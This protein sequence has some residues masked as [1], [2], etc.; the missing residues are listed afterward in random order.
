MLRDVAIPN[1]L[2]VYGLKEDPEVAA[3]AD[4]IAFY[5]RQWVEDIGFCAEEV[6][7]SKIPP[8]LVSDAQLKNLQWK[9][10]IVVGT[11]NDVVKELGLTFEKPT[12]KMLEKDGKRI[13]VVELTRSKLY[14]LPNTLRTL[15]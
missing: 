2:V 7:Q 9:S 11:N 5:L 3:Q 13:L 12:I 15:D 8:L 10:I 4:K 6:K 14:S 1:V